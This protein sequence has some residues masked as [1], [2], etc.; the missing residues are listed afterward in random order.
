MEFGHIVEYENLGDAWREM[1]DEDN[2]SECTYLDLGVGDTCITLMIHMDG[3]FEVGQ[4]EA[5]RPY[6]SH[7]TG[8]SEDE[9][10]KAFIG[11]CA[12][13]IC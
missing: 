7:Y 12:S 3:G 6:I 13:L 5:L 11:A 2:F 1:V 10:I 8:D 9:A 4:G